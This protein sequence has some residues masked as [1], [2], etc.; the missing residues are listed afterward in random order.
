MSKKFP[1]TEDGRNTR[2]DLARLRPFIPR[3]MSV[4]EEGGGAGRYEVDA[5]L[6]RLNRNEGSECRCRRVPAAAR[7]VNGRNTKALATACMLE[8]IGHVR[9]GGRLSRSDVRGLIIQ[10]L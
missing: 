1:E 5:M 10:G 7:R 9:R 6:E 3:R 8:G 4:A 2:K